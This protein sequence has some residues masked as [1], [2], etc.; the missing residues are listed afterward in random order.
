MLSE[1]TSSWYLF[2]D[3]A[4]TTSAAADKL[5]DA[6]LWRKQPASPAASSPFAMPDALE[7]DKA[8]RAIF[9]QLSP[10]PL[11]LGALYGA[12]VAPCCGAVS[13]FVGTTRDTFDGKQ[14]TRLEYEVY[15]RMAE[16]KMLQIAADA[17]GKWTDVRRIVMAHRSGEVGVGLPSVVIH[18][19]SCHRPEG[20]AAVKYLID[21]LKADVPIWKREFYAGGA[22]RRQ[23]VEGA[24]DEEPQTNVA[25]QDAEKKQ[26]EQVSA[27]KSNAECCGRHKHKDL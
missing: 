16:S 20:L 23:R 4:G 27:W 22:Q 24:D 5:G 1:L 19:A 15:G 7:K 8:L 18:V 26:E 9:L 17:M 11:D 12:C 25:Q 13:S 21:T 3:D 2:G 6:S 14:V 10:S